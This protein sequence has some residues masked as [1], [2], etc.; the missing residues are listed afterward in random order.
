[1]SKTAMVFFTLL[2]V[3]AGC[4]IAGCGSLPFSDTSTPSETPQKVNSGVTG[5]DTT[6]AASQ[7]LQFGDTIEKAVS[8]DIFDSGNDIPVN[9]SGENA[10]QQTVS[11]EKR[12][13]SIR[14]TDLDE[15]GDAISWTFV[16][17][18]G[19][20]FSIVTYNSNGV[21]ISNSQGTL[22]QPE[23]FTDRIISPRDLF[24]RNRAVIFNTT[25]TGTAV[26]RDISLGGGN[27]TISIKGH[28]TPR[29]LVFDATTGVL[30]ST[31]D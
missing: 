27:Y 8:T 29:I 11:L 28:G 19:E 16:I 4:F 22:R 15:N 20:K 30:T 5:Q 26:T 6:S 12:F 3:V 21:Q 24:D 25:R 17:E 10:S 9:I 18:H 13:K 23:I 2:L 31:N 14:G 1:M 7:R